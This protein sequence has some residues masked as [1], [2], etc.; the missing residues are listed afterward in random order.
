MARILLVD[1]QQL[2]RRGL[3]LLLE[4]EDGLEVAAEAADGHEALAVLRGTEVDVVLTD[5]RM[6]G[7]D[8][9]ELVRQLA[10]LHPGLPAVVLTT[11]DDED[12][13]TGA[14]AAGAAGFLLKDVSTTRLAEAIG[15]VASGGLVIDPRVARLALGRGA[16][17]DDPLAV[18]TGTERLV[19]ELVAER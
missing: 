17:R 14:M 16:Q 1:D 8:G 11:F 3:R 6:P 19:A 9:V 13:I 10:V 5:A 15:E 7:M 18:L 2:L 12:I 4:T